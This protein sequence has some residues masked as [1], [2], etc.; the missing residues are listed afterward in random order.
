M[1]PPV[2]FP[3]LTANPERVSVIWNITPEPN[4]DGILVDWEPRRNVCVSVSANVDLAGIKT[5][6]ALKGAAVVDIALTWA[7]QGTSFRGCIERKRLLRVAE[8]QEV[9]LEGEILGTEAAGKVELCVVVIVGFDQGSVNS[10]LSPTE[11]TSIVWRIARRLLLE[12]TAAQFPMETVDFASAGFPADAPWR[13]EWNPAFPGDL[14]LGTVRLYLNSAHPQVVKLLTAPNAGEELRW[15]QD[16][17]RYDVVSQLARGSLESSEFLDCP[18]A[19][20]QG[21]VGAHVY[22][23]LSFSFPAETIPSLADLK[24]NQPGDFEARLKAAFAMLPR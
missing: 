6:C 17:L 7:S 8:T 20:P 5:D 11:P 10:P 14:L 21:S 18:D 15:L 2:I 23:L 13:L 9:V 3:F 12:G 1:A 19:H 24:R 4:A 16:M 22:A